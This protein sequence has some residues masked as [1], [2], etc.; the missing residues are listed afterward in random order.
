MANKNSAILKLKHYFDLMSKDFGKPVELNKSSPKDKYYYSWNDES[1]RTK[2]VESDFIRI[3]TF[4]AIKNKV[5]SFAFAFTTP[6]DFNKTLITVTFK[7][8]DEITQG[9]TYNFEKFKEKVKEFTK[10]ISILRDLGNL[11]VHGVETSL[12][13]IFEFDKQKTSNE[14]LIADYEKKLK[15]LNTDIE[16]KLLL[17]RDEHGKKKASLTRKKNTLAKYRDSRNKELGIDVLEAQ[18]AELKATLKYDVSKKKA[19]LKIN[20]VEKEE[21]ELNIE[22]QELSRQ[23]T[24]NVTNLIKG[25]PT[26]IQKII[27][28]KK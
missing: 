1:S 8:G 19:S 4:G 12:K 3:Y 9:S 21:R 5:M 7:I 13:K 20:A 28:E 17:L 18:L 14:A 15:K 10:V 2:G 11:N 24:S 27:R 22:V 16:E 6:E 23:A 26:H 25:Y